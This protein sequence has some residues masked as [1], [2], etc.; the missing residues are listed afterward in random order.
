MSKMQQI[1][2]SVSQATGLHTDGNAGLLY[3][4][5]NGYTIDAGL[6]GQNQYTISVS[7]RGAGGEEP[8]RNTLKVLV[9]ECKAISGCLVS[10]RKVSF[11]VRSSVK[12]EVFAENI[13]TALDFITS[14]LHQYGYVNVC[15]RCG[16]PAPTEVVSIG[17]GRM[18]L[19]QPCYEQVQ[20]ERTERQMIKESKPE[21]VIGGLVGALLGS[22]LG[23]AAII[24]FSRLGYT[25]AASGIT[26]GVCTRKGYELLGG[27][28]TVK[29]IVISILVML[30]MVYVGDR[31]DWAMLVAREW[32]ENVFDAFRAIPALIKE[33]VIEQSSYI[34]NLVKLYLFALLGAVPAVIA[35]V[36]GKSVEN[37]VSRMQ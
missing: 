35:M 19:C 36:K 8:D 3:G 33:D 9:R 26:M 29:G 4:Y 17:L 2:S 25:T 32:G 6:G 21:N 7:V 18:T 13:R 24:L 28:M 30:L 34:G 22:L 15:Q 16:Q 20:K 37:R 31:F 5:Y 11:P 10:G 23:V 12:T 14:K 1:A 27:K